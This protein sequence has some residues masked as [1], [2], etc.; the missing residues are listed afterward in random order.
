MAKQTRGDSLVWGII[1]IIVGGIFLLQQFD[2]N[3]FDQVWRF[4]PVILII[5]G[6]NKLMLGLKE[7]SAQDQAPS[8]PATV[9]A[10]IEFRPKRV[11]GLR[12]SIF[13]DET[14][15]RAA[16]S[17]INQRLMASSEWRGHIFCL[18]PVAKYGKVP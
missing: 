13:S 4:W 15:M 12:T 7:K 5:W 6:A 14:F 8:S 11:N 2:V 17:T 9:V 16:N 10:S 18:Y 3:I 1:L